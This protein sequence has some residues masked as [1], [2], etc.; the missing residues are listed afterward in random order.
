MLE[1]NER[2]NY[3]QEKTFYKIGLDVQMPVWNTDKA[4]FSECK[5][6][7]VP[8]DVYMITKYQVKE[9]VI[10]DS[11]K[12][13]VAFDDLSNLSEDPLNPVEKPKVIAKVRLA[14]YAKQRL[15]YL[16]KE[17]EKKFEKIKDTMEEN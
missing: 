9:D 5:D 6:N 4:D 14:Y 1:N 17:F 7:P 15:D 10:I 3:E 2:L 8:D 11:A 12:E 16:E 13:D